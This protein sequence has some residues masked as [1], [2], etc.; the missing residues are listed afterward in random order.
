MTHHI[1]CREC[2]FEALVDDSDEAGD[3]AWTH[4]QETGHRVASD[5]IEGDAEMV[6][7][8]GEDDRTVQ[9]GQVEVDVKPGD[10]VVDVFDRTEGPLEVT[11]ENTVLCRPFSTTRRKPTD[12]DHIS[13]D[14]EEVEDGDALELYRLPVSER[15]AYEEALE[16]DGGQIES[17]CDEQH[18]DNF[19]SVAVEPLDGD[20][21]REVCLDHAI[22][23]VDRI[24]QGVRR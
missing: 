9:I 7:D 8:G 12:K 11:A 10:T 15:P 24:G 18:C 21:R 20:G 1:C 13:F 5:S 2:E 17:Q 6:T 19:P 4:A 14:L 23:A 22:S 16:T 3:R